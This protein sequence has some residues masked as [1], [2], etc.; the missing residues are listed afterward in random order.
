MDEGYTILTAEEE[1]EEEERGDGD[2]ASGEGK[3]SPVD[4]EAKGNASL[5]RCSS[6]PRCSSLLRFTSLPKG[7]KAFSGRRRTTKGPPSAFPRASPVG[8]L[9][10]VLSRRTS[11]HN[12]FTGM[13][14]SHISQS[15][16]RP[17]DHHNNVAFHRSDVTNQVKENRWGYRS[18]AA[19]ET[20]VEGGGKKGK[21]EGT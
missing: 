21:H 16:T 18:H 6:S 9:I 8:I 12:V 2:A 19:C 17:S 1:E 11:S 10:A 15:S 4:V 7:K 5:V 14:D 20:G 13:R 3:G